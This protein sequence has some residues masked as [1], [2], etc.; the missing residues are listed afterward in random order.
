MS[1]GEALMFLAGFVVGVL[2]TVVA[3]IW[4]VAKEG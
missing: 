2:A 1:R 4:W 3:L